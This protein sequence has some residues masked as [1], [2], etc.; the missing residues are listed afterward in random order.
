MPS[1]SLVTKGID[2]DQ[3]VLTS[4]TPSSASIFPLG[5]VCND[6][7]NTLERALEAA[8]ATLDV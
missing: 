6:G 4:T 1:V 7:S 8:C 3:S 5:A 2:K